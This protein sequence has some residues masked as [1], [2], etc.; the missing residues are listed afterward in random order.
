MMQCH[1]LKLLT[2]ETLVVQLFNLVSY[3]IVL[4]FDILVI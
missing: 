4:L 3:L 1:V 2:P